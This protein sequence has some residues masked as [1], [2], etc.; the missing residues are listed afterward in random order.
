M[1]PAKCGIEFSYCGV[2]QNRGLRYWWLQF[3]LDKVFEDLGINSC[4]IS[5]EMSLHTH[6]IAE[7]L[8]VSYSFFYFYCWEIHPTN[9]WNLQW[10][11]YSWSKTVKAKSNYYSEAKTLEDLTPGC[12]FQ[13]GTNKYFFFYLNFLFQSLS[14][15]HMLG[16]GDD[17]Y[18]R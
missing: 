18:E 4:N 5:I 9:V 12:Y 6:F 1:W 10:V 7:K 3:E 8:V 11:H 13:A 16:L 15:H 2:L 17:Y 14:I